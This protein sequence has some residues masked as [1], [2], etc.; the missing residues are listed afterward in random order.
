VATEPELGRVPDGGGGAEMGGAFPKGKY[1]S[2]TPEREERSLRR[3][4]ETG[5]NKFRSP[6]EKRC[7]CEEK[8]K[9]F[10]SSRREEKVS[11]KWRSPRRGIRKW[12]SQKGGRG[13]VSQS[14][15]K[16]RIK[17]KV[18]VV[19][20]WGNQRSKSH[21][22]PSKSIRERYPYMAII[23]LIGKVL[24]KEERKYYYVK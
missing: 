6:S 9:H 19:G 5:G 1:L 3:G 13:E 17:G 22:D 15:K 24:K 21:P 2:A 18:S 4:G 11:S 20:G 16:L 12:I 23:S 10:R 7:Q 14:S 8:K